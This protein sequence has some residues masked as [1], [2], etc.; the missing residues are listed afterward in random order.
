MVDS[1]AP[2]R[3]W[4]RS[5]RVQSKIEVFCSA[6]SCLNIA[7]DYAPAACILSAF[8]L[9]VAGVDDGLVLKTGGSETKGPVAGRFCQAGNSATHCSA[10]RC[11]R[12]LTPGGLPQKSTQPLTQL[13]MRGIGQLVLPFLVTIARTM[14]Q[15]C[16]VLARH[17]RLD[18][19][20]LTTTLP[21]QTTF[22]G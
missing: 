3:A 20:L 14:L 17:L 6:H 9:L 19:V 16:K 7:A 22:K 15:L 13:W 12:R 8:C 18:L 1:S 2:E 21:S 5:S 11:H 10:C 4:R